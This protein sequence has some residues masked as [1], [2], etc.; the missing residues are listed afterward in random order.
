MKNNFKKIFAVLLAVIFVIS[1][2]PVSAFATDEPPALTLPKL[3]KYYSAKATSSSFLT[4]ALQNTLK[5]GIINHQTNI[6]I[7]GYNVEYNNNNFYELYSYV[8]TEIPEAFDVDTSSFG[9]NYVY[10]DGSHYFTDFTVDYYSDKETFDSMLAECEEVAEEMI[11]DIIDSDYDDATKALLIHDRIALRNEYDLTYGYNSNGSFTMYGALVNKTSVCQGYVMAYDYVLNMVGIE[12]EFCASDNMG[13][14]W[15]IVYIDGEPYHVDITFD[16]P[17]FD[18][19]GRVY[20]DNFLISTTEKIRR[21][22]AAGYGNAGD[23]STAPQ[24]TKYDNYFWRDVTSSFQPA[25]DDIYYIERDANDGEIKRMSDNTTVY[26]FSEKWFIGRYSYRPEL[27]SQLASDG[28]YLFFNLSD[29]II[30]LN[31]NTKTTEK[32][33]KPNLSTYGDYYGIYGLKLEDGNFV[34]DINYDVQLSSDTV[35]LV[36]PSRD[37]LVPYIIPQVEYVD[38]GSVTLKSTAGHQYKISGGNWQNSNTFTGLNA[39]TS[40]TFYE[41]LAT[42]DCIVGETKTTTLKFQG[43]PSRPNSLQISDDYVTLIKADNCEY[44]IDGSNWQT[45]NTF[46]GLSANTKYTFYQRYLD[47][48]EISEGLTVTTPNFKPGDINGDAKIN[49]SDVS[50]LAQYVAKWNLS[51]DS[52]YTTV[53]LDPTGDG[54]VNLA[55]VSLL[56]QFVAKWEVT[57]DITPYSK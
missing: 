55:D 49:L 29:E 50:V 17:I 19:T 56:A 23:F 10:K 48:E 30:R 28:E 57:V 6:D 40:Y 43:K 4:E 33:Y 36:N 24:S 42:G 14:V 5:Q 44:S 2:F 9:G 22:I 35:L 3:N 1:A 11:A 46:T 41:K 16:D 47:G 18:V 51:Q 34:L 54:S 13:H 15:N 20:H 27:Y 32:V 38:S 39:D 45:S 53:S 12:A 21:N 52:D 7:S 8:Y 26:K 31:V 25:G 37:L